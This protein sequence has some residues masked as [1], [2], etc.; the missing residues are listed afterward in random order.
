MP[1]SSKL[2]TIVSKILRNFFPR[3]KSGEKRRRKKQAEKSSGKGRN[4]KREAKTPQEK[5]ETEKGRLP[6]L[7]LPA[8]PACGKRFF[9]N[10]GRNTARTTNRRKIFA[11]HPKELSAKAE[12]GKNG[13]LQE[14]QGDVC[15]KQEKRDAHFR[16]LLLENFNYTIKKNSTLKSRVFLP[17]QNI[18]H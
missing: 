8:L 15:K 14:K 12:H 11:E 17:T 6:F 4:R 13:F 16:A 1:L 2:L 18:L 9:L 10:G 3:E 7:A 5:A